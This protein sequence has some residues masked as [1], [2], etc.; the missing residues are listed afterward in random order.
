MDSQNR[1]QTT[2]IVTTVGRQTPKRDFGDELVNVM[3]QTAR[4]GA[5]IVGGAVGGSPVVSAAVSGVT[6][7]VSAVT[8]VTSRSASTIVSPGSNVNAAVNSAGAAP[9]EQGGAM[10][11]LGRQE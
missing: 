11:T 8:G 5:G 9:L 3:G 4:I 7:A 1:I 10:D 6:G 2:S